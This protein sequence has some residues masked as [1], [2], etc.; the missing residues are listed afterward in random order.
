VGKF[1]KL[2][3]RSALGLLSPFGE[4]A[5]L[6]ILDHPLWQRGHGDTSWTSVFMGCDI[7]EVSSLEVA[8]QDLQD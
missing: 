3:N 4:A 1:S 5:T 2:T 8:L 7:Q 6:S